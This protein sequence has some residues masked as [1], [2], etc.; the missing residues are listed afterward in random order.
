MRKYFN[1]ANSLLDVYVFG[2]T[3]RDDPL[4]TLKVVG[5]AL[6]LR[7]MALTGD[8]SRGEMGSNVLILAKFAGLEGEIKKG[9][10]GGLTVGLE[11]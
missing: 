3:L 4:L 9:E 6:G 2:T 1:V 7:L 5:L 8:S 10:G 11:I